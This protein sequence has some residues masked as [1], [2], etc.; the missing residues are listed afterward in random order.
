MECEGDA[1]AVVKA[2]FKL[3]E[4]LLSPVYGFI[5]TLDVF[6]RRMYYIEFL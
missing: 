6:N 4:P 2:V 3:I 5:D 1:R